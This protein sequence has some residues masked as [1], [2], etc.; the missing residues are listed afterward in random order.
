MVSNNHRIPRHHHGPGGGTDYQETRKSVLFNRLSADY[1][2][3]DQL[4]AIVGYD[5][6][7][8]DRGMFATYD[9]NSELW[10][11]LKYNF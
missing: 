2:L 3:N 7:H 1:A 10:F 9:N 6:F 11:K 4:H 8:A 5:L